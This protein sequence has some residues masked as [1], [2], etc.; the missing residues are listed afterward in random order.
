MFYY[1]YYLLLLFVY[2]AIS[3]YIEM[4]PDDAAPS[5]IMKWVNRKCWKRNYD[6]GNENHLIQSDVSNVCEG[7]YQVGV[8]NIIL[9]IMDNIYKDGTVWSETYLKR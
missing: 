2:S 7:T 6:R 8:S 3:K 1:D 9:I 5:Y 4:R